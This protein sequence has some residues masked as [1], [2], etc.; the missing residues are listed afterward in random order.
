MFEPVH[1]S[2]PD[3]AGRGVANPV[4]TMWAT[5]MMLDHL[6]EPDAARALEAAFEQAMAAGVRTADLG[7]SAGT[8]EFTREVLA[9]C[10]A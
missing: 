2:A 5:A 6:G 4:G 3:I 8:E 10:T 1:G 7:G 9:R